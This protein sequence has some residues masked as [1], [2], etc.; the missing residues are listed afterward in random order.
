MELQQQQF[1]GQLMGQGYQ[2]ILSKL[3]LQ[4]NL[5]SSIN[6]MY[7]V[8][9]RSGGLLKGLGNVAGM[10]FGGPLGGALMGKAFPGLFKDNPAKGW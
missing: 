1:T 6:S 10:V 4:G 2:D 7:G 5:A 9:Q 8:N 3:G